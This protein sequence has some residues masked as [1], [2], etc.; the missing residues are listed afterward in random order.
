MAVAEAGAGAPR[1]CAGVD[2]ALPLSCSFTAEPPVAEAPE[3]EAPEA[4]APVAEAPVAEALEPEAP[5]AEAPVAE[6]PVA[7]APM[8]EAPVAE[9]PEAEAPEAEAPVAEAP[10]AEALE[11]EAPVAEA[12]VA[13]APVAEAPMAEAPVAEA[14]M[15]E[16]PMAEAPVAEA[17]EAEAPVA[18]LKASI[19][20]IV[21]VFA[22][23]AGMHSSGRSLSKE[24]LRVLLEREL[25]GFLESGEDQD[26][27]ME[28]VFRSLDTNEDATVSF[29]EFLLLV[30]G[31]LAACHKHFQEEGAS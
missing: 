7:E 28:K 5:V 4:E 2:I 3:A 8:A 30:A 21:H 15:A 20:M 31:L 1:V 13:E 29:Q 16:A 25:P 26:D 9:A 11:P 27:A 17:L 18:N 23:Y 22:R 12:P 6:A 19:V 24:E 14:P 10:V